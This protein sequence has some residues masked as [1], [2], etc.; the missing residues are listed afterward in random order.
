MPVDYRNYPK[1]WKQISNRIR[2]E[3]A[4]GKCEQC[5]VAHGDI[6]YWLHGEW[7]SFERLMDVL[8]NSGIDLISEAG[9]P[10][11]KMPTKIILGTAHLDHDVTNNEE[12]N[13][14]ALCQLCHLNHDRADNAWRA[15]YGKLSPLIQLKLPLIFFQ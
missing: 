15:K 14:M 1:D 12:S 4:E 11:D 13:L 6:G 10:G 5:G 2:F 3:R 8:D 7:H 9:V